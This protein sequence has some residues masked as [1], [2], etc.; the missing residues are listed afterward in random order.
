MSEIDLQLSKK[1]MPKS[2]KFLET[3]QGEG[4]PEN[5]KTKISFSNQLHQRSDRQDR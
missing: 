5:A 1:I 4:E 2:E 3:D